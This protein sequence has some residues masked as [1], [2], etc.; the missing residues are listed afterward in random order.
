MKLSEE[1]YLIIVLFAILHLLEILFSN[2]MDNEWKCKKSLFSGAESEYYICMVISG[3]LYQLNDLPS[4][5][6]RRF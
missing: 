2:P 1:K 3:C 6:F 4:I 5:L